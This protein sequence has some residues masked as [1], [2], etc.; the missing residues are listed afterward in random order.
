M[1]P[2]FEFCTLKFKKKEKYIQTES[3]KEEGKKYVTQTEQEGRTG[4]ELQV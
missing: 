1:K 3:R 4:H 2:H